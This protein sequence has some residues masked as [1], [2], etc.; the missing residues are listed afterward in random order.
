MDVL[1]EK[2]MKPPQITVLI[3][4]FNQSRFICNAMDS[5]VAQT[6]PKENFEII[7]INDGSTD[8]TSFALSAYR[9]SIRLIERENRG[10]VATCNEGLELARGSYF[11]RV[12]SDDWVAPEWLECLLN[13]ITGNPEA[14]CVYPDRY[15]VFGERQHYIKAEP[16]NIYTLEA[17]GTL[18]IT[19][20][21]R[22]AGGF[23]PFLLEEYDLYLRLQ[24]EGVFTHF[25]RP[26]YMYRKHS[27][28]M[29]YSEAWRRKA[30]HE[31]LREW[32]AE[33][34][35]SAGSDPDLKDVL[36]DQR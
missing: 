7:V 5:L 16:G 33:A 11:A 6:L 3:A 22:K 15:E 18:F 19:E 36:Q 20:G 29:T 17:C 35:L 4:T 2:K 31:L 23:R 10:L 34:L 25:P 8:D 9:D 27:E 28:S 32:G 21:L 12:D 13:A 30:W 1:I 14:C 26:L 24:K